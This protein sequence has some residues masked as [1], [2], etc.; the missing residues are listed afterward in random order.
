MKNEQEIVNT[1]RKQR[2]ELISH[3]NLSNLVKLYDYCIDL[4]EKRWLAQNGIIVK[5]SLPDLKNILDSVG[6]ENKKNN[7]E[8]ELIEKSKCRDC[9]NEETEEDIRYIKRNRL[10]MLI[11]EN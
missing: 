11:Q 9:S 4:H 2:E 10:G 1:L 3:P 7:E 5:S 8:I 6:D